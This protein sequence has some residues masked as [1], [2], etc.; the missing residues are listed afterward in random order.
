M[1]LVTALLVLAASDW[2]WRWPFAWTVP[3]PFG[4]TWSA[5]LTFTWPTAL[6]LVPVAVLLGWDRYRSLGHALT[7]RYL[8]ARNGSTTRVTV[9]LQRTGIIGWHLTQTFF[10]RRSGLLTLSA[11]TAAGAGV[12]HVVDIDADDGLALADR[13]VPG[14]LR[15]FLTTDADIDTAADAT[16]DA[17]PDSAAESVPSIPGAS[18]SGAFMPS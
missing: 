7:D 17:I 15:P 2:V 18:P 13:A 11:I 12:Y 1:L 5:V 16:P 14:L 6:A 10:Q 4:W 9:A 3:L 8:V